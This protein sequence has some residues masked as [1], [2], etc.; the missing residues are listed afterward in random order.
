MDLSHLENVKRRF[1]Q[2]ADEQERKGIR[3]Y[4]QPLN[5]SDDYDWVDMTIEELVDA[6]KYMLAEKHKRQEKEEFHNF[7]ANKVRKLTDDPEIE[8]WMDKLEGK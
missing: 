3:K 1:N 4:G 6:T 2:V 5:P 7:I 8:H